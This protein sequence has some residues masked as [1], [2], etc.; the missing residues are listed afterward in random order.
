MI[1]GLL[2]T[3]LGLSAAC[4][5]LYRCAVFALPVFIGFSIAFWAMNAGAGLGSVAVGFAAGVIAF[6]I[7]QLAFSRSRSLAMRWTIILLFAV[8]AA[9]TGYSLVLQLSRLGVPSAA[10]RHA[11]AIIGAVI[12]GFTAIAQLAK[13]SGERAWLEIVLRPLTPS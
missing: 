11:L 2:V 1:F 13:S 5:L 4:A 6:L 7:G 10:W 8:P 9:I 3:A 12:V